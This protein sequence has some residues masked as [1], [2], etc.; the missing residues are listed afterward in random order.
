[1]FRDKTIVIATTNQ[2]KLKEF[3]RYFDGQSI[4]VKGL[5]EFMD[6]PAVV[7]DGKT[8]LEN[9]EIKARK[10]AQHINLP[11]IADD[12]GLC[13]EAL[14]GRP[15][16]Y[17][18][19][20]AGE[21]TTDQMNNL[22]LLSELRRVLGSKELKCPATF[23]C[24]LVYFDPLTNQFLHTEGNCHGFIISE[25]RGEN[26]FGYDPLF[27]LPEYN[28]TMAELTPEIKNQISHRSGAIKKM[29]EFT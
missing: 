14:A 24:A 23:V 10:I 8:F 21:Q 29:L 19:R 2:G 22:K 26:G 16:I 9:A 18:A 20:Y 7:E 4:S 15:G 13:V 27:W 1:M 3:I 5:S 25:P 17:S 28:K 6:L 11:V 12:S